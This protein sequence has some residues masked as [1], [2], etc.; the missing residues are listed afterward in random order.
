MKKVFEVLKLIIEDIIQ[1]I[2]FLFVIIKKV[3]RGEKIVQDHKWEEYKQ[4]VKSI[5]PQEVMRKDWYWILAIM[6]ALVIG[7]LLSAKYYQMECNNIIIENYINKD[8]PEWNMSEDSSS[9]FP[10]ETQL[11]DSPSKQSSYG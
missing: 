6:F 11:P 8:I 4:T 2:K 3:F 7:I 1:D 5:T 9:I 10:F